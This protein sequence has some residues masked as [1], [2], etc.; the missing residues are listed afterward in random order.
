MARYPAAR[1]A[2]TRERIL[3]AAARRFRAG[4]VDGSGLAAVMSD[5]ELTNGAFY[6]HFASKHELVAEVLAE[7]IGRQADIFESAARHEDGL[8]R[9][10]DAYLSPSHR[11]DVAGGCISAALVGELAHAPADVRERYT[12]ELPRM[13][14]AFRTVARMPADAPDALVL[15]RFAVLLG[16]LQLS[17]ALRD[18]ELSAAVLEE[19]RRSIRTLLAT[20]AGR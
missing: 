7:Q 4:G 8:E 5:A 19:G 12:T 2:E 9:V 6:A 20:D 15:A 14:A 3:A 18:P 10:I 13:I 16:A 11:D 1:K 17:R